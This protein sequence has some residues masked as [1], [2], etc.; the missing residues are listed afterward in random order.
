[1]PLNPGGNVYLG[2]GADRQ[3]GNYLPEPAMLAATIEPGR[4]DAKGCE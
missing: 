4:V 1:M 3:L 2:N